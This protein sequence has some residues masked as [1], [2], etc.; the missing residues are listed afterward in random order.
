MRVFKFGGASVNSASAIR[1]VA[2]IVNQ[3]GGSPLVVVISAM[4]K[5]PICWRK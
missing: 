2:H 5:P 3:Q 1:N 4:G